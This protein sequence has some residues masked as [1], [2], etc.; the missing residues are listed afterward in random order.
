MERFQFRAE[1]ALMIG[2]DDEDIQRMI[3]RIGLSPA[4]GAEIAA[5]VASLV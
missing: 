4:G 3:N 2:D 5:A 1:V